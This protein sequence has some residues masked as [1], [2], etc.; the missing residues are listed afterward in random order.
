[1]PTVQLDE[2]LIMHAKR[3]PRL[4]ELTMSERIAI[5]LFW[6]KG[7]RVN[8]LS[9]VFNCARNTIYYSCLTGDSE[10]YPANGTANKINKYVDSVGIEKAWKDNVT[11]EMILAVNAAN[12]ALI[13]RNQLSHAA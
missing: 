2:T 3:A 12:K 13:K 8:V 11:D 4:D 7:T 9:K 6:R 1:M 5:N 10:S